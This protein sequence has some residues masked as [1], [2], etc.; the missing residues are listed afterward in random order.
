MSNVKNN[1]N[2][3]ICI[4]CQYCRD[5]YFCSWC[6]ICENCDNCNNCSHSEN[7]RFC[8]LC[9]NCRN[10]HLCTSSSCCDSCSDC[11][12][13]IKCK[14][15]RDCSF[16]VGCED[17]SGR[18]FFIKNVEIPEDAYF[19][20]VL[21][22]NKINAREALIHNDVYIDDGKISVNGRPAKIYG[23]TLV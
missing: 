13:C 22:D 3:K 2:L 10:C 1:F 12:K 14:N 11:F 19:I 7:L 9:D 16:C 4:G 17:L 21:G 20:T 15:C 5:C 6:E 8:Q 18:A 23:V